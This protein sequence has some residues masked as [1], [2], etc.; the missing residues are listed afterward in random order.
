V[1]FGKNISIGQAEAELIEL[2]ELIRI[3]NHLLKDMKEEK[4]GDKADRRR[5]VA[6]IK[7]K[8]DIERQSPYMA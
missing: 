6:A 2:A 1:K 7:L 3:T 5:H 4:Y 8:R